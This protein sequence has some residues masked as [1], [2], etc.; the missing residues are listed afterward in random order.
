MSDKLSFTDQL[1]VGVVFVAVL[2]V[3]TGIGR[4]IDAVSCHARWG[5][6]ADYN[7]IGGCFV[8]TSQGFVP[9]D[10]VRITE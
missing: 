2:A 6:R 3:L 4:G 5:D 10:R 1:L 7:F 8:D 9:E